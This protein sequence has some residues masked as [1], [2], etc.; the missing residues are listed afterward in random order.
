MG[1]NIEYFTE[2]KLLA[3]IWGELQ[4][5]NQRISRL[6]M[7]V[8][9]EVAS[10]EERSAAGVHDTPGEGAALADEQLSLKQAP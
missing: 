4:E 6:T 8:A 5:A 9:M 7:L 10:A 1:E 2:K 3:L